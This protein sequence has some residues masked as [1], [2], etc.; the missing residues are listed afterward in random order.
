MKQVLI[1]TEHRGVWYAEVAETADL[2]ATTLTDLKNCRMAIYWGTTK[3]LHELCQTGPTSSSKISSPADI[4]V[5][6]KVT[7]VFA[8]TEAAAE[9][10]NSHCK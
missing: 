3:G 9:K 10:W 7:G 2:T 6:H 8:I 5:L 4:L 1:T